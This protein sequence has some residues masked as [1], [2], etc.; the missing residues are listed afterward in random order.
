MDK[1]LVAS[2]KRV[3][4]AF[5]PTKPPIKVR[6]ERGWYYIDWGT[7]VGE[8]KYRTSKLIEMRDTLKNRLGEGGA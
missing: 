7:S 1:N 8:E 5:N 4:G 3:Y 2:Y 6:Y